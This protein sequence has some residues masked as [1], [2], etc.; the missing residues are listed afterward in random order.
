VIFSYVLTLLGVC[1]LAVGSLVILRA[2]KGGGLSLSAAQPIRIVGRQAVGAGSTLML[3]EVEGARMLIGVSRGGIAVLPP[4]APFVPSAVD[5]P[6][7]PRS[8]DFARDERRPG[9]FR[10]T[11]RRAGERW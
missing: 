10:A 3:V 6:V 11:L 9:S 8:L 2:A 1:G 5:A 7:R 4:T